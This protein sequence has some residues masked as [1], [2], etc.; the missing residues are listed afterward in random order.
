MTLVGKYEHLFGYF[1]ACGYIPGITLGKNRGR[2]LKQRPL[3]C[4]E[5]LAPKTM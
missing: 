4:G 5:M 1:R 2:E 3:Y